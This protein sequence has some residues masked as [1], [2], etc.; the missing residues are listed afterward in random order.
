MNTDHIMIISFVWISN[1]R[2]IF[3]MP[4]KLKLMEEIIFSVRLNKTGGSALEL[5]VKEHW[6]AKTLL[7]NSALSLYLVIYLFWW[8]SGWMQGIFLLL[9]NNFK[10]GQYVLVLVKVFLILFEIR[11]WYFDK[12]RLRTS[13][14][15]WKIKKC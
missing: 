3:A 6:L 10:T 11:E 14:Y 7:N 13:F 15:F 12:L 5:F 9:R 8:S 4:S 1:F 2:I